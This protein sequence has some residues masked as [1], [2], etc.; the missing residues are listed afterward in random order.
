[1]GKLIDGN[2]IAQKIEK[3]LAQKTARLKTQ[4][5]IPKLV[6]ILVGADKSS[7]KYVER[8]QA[9]ADKVGVL[10][11][12]KRFKSNI[13]T[14]KLKKAILEIQK[15][16]SISGL[17]VQLPLPKTIDKHT[18]LNAVRPE[19][20]VD[21]LNAKNQ[22]K[23]KKGQ[24]T[25][26]PPTPAAILEILKHL[27]V[28]LKNKKV[29]VIG[30]GILVGKPIAAIL[31]AKGA[32][33]RVCGKKAK[34]VK[35]ICLNS[36]IIITG[37]GKKHIVTKNMVR[38]KSIVI[39]AGITFVGKKLYGDV[40]YKPVSQVAKYTTPTPGGVGPITVA[41]LLK[42]TVENTKHN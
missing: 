39:D 14:Q 34:N 31:R 27:K 12:L 40:D 5:K 6:V 2:K 10:F 37:V 15:D 21:C 36:D 7:K 4:N 35:K 9:S 1:M 29:A 24:K 30:E 19:I 32:R 41:S 42:N 11:I 18:I 25:F 8:K 22:A 20:D 17:I 38:K 26:T 13:T 16:K 3:E 23:L 28:K 33:V